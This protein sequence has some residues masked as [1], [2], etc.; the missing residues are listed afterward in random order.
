[1]ITTW[2][3]V[4]TGGFVG[5]IARFAISQRL[6]FRGGS[7]WP[8]GTWLANVSGSLV[9]GWMVGAGWNPQLLMFAGTG[10]LGSFTTYSTLHWEGHQ[11]GL[12]KEWQK[13]FLYLGITYTTGILATFVGLW[14]GN[15]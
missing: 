6:N 14:V 10:F 7:P 1:M 5:A 15:R 12:K 9:L 3:L 8:W 2:G 13:M 4:A 11:F